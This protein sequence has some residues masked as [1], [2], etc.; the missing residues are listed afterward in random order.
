MDQ[1]S[2]CTSCLISSSSTTILLDKS[3]FLSSRVAFVTI[4][5]LTI[6]VSMSPG[7]SKGIERVKVSG[8]V[9]IDGKP[10]PAG[11]IRVFPKGARDSSSNLDSEGRFELRSYNP[12]D[13]VPLGTHKVTVNG[14]QM[15]SPYKKKWYAPPKYSRIS[16]SGLT[17]EVTGSTEDA[18]IELTWSGGKPF[19][20]KVNRSGE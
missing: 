9:L 12:G 18:I 17:L 10:V 8:H 20:Q 5:G 13:G 11:F 4:V 19:V 15:V 3:G 14:S 6:L 2:A 1:A 16:T 7:C